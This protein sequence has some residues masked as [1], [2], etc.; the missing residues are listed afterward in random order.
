MCARAAS[1]LY[2]CRTKERSDSDYQEEICVCVLVLQPSAH[3][4]AGI[5]FVRGLELDWDTCSWRKTPGATVRG[6]FCS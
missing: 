5:M 6:L 4:T 2:L 1:C 3:R